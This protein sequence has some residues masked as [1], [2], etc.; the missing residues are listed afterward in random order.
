MS[1]AEPGP[2]ASYNSLQDPHLGGFFANTR[3]KKHLKKSGLVTKSGK[4]VSEK[5]YRLQMAKK[6][7]KDHVRDLLATAIVHKALDMENDSNLSTFTG[8]IEKDRYKTRPGM[9]CE[10][11][12][13]RCQVGRARIRGIRSQYE[14][15]IKRC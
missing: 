4:I 15:S 5:T 6:E 9:V 11:F 10:Y 3:M 2:L 7:H 13:Y 1:H 14:Q 12:W 8:N